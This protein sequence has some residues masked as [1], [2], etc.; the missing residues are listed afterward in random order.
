[1][2]ERTVTEMVRFFEVIG[3]NLR[4]RLKGLTTDQENLFALASGKVFSGKP[5][6]IC[7]KHALE[8][9]DKR[10]GYT[11]QKKDVGRLQKKIRAQLRSLPDRGT[12]ASRER[13]WEE[14]KR[15]YER[16][17]MLRRAL[18]PLEVLRK[19]IRRVLYARRY[20]IACSRWANFRRHRLR[21]HPAHGK[22]IEYIQPRWPSLTVHYHYIGMPNT[23][24]IAENTMRQLERRLKTIEGFGNL[25]TARGYMN[26]L[27]AYL[28]TKPFTDCRGRRKYRN[29]LSRLELA[30]AKLPH[31]DWLKLCLKHT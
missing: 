9:L 2:K 18:R 16:L 13:T 15:G 14:V 4:Y 26:L 25:R 30:G 24:N 7:I 22:I 19:A 1:M 8:S 17:R 29:G 12:G 3:D 31:K 20:S 23:N 28:R 6:Q 10:L 5:H 11:R 21:H 27:I